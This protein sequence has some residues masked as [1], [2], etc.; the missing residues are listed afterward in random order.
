MLVAANA[1]I[2]VAKSLFYPTISLTGFL[3]GV[4]GDLTVVP[5]RDRRRRGPWAR[6]CFSRSSRPGGFAGTSRRRRRDSMPRSPNTRKP[7]STATARSPTRWSR[8]RS[9][10]SSAATARLG[11]AALQD[12]SDLSRERYESGLASYIEI[13]TADQQLF[14]QQLLLA[15]TRGAEL[16]A[17][18]EL[19]RALGGG[20][21]PQP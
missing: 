7:R 10:P 18:A 20:W 19:Y 17:R 16:R 14:E 15:Q 3:G 9:W 5:R 4:S 21:Q 6:A 13:L 12:A 1:D 2:G 11:V 8:F